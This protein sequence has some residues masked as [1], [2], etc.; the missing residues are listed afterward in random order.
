M[1]NTNWLLISIRF[2]NHF[3]NSPSEGIFDS[4]GAGEKLN[5]AFR[6][7]AIVVRKFAMLPSSLFVTACIHFKACTCHWAF[8]VGFWIRTASIDDKNCHGRFFPFDFF[9]DPQKLNFAVFQHKSCEFFEPL[10]QEMLECLSI[11]FPQ[12]IAVKDIKTK[13][14][15]LKLI[16]EVEALRKQAENEKQLEEA[17]RLLRQQLEIE[18]E[19]GKEKHKEIEDLKKRIAQLEEIKKQEVIENSSKKSLLPLSAIEEDI[20]FFFFLS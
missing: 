18:K 19:K 7:I 9:P 12:S 17:N 10:I 20:L 15:E 8:C 13:V 1:S 6:E 14:R 16:Q 4:L 5:Q 3:R 11:K 2:E